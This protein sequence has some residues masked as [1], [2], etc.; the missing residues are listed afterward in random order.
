MKDQNDFFD[1]VI[2]D[3]V[4][5][6]EPDFDGPTFMEFDDAAGGSD[7]DDEDEPTDMR[8][9]VLTKNGMVALL[10]L[11]TTAAG[12]QIVRVDPRQPLPTAQTYEDEA[13]AARWFRRSLATSRKNGWQVAY[14]GE[15]L[16]G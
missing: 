12:G 2:D 8:T 13:S 9:A 3:E 1:D 4:I 7:D 5:G 15:P 11:K 14:E 10:S 16:F 6:D